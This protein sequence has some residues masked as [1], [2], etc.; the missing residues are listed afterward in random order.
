MWILSNGWGF[1]RYWQNKI[2]YT[3]HNKKFKLDNLLELLKRNGFKYTIYRTQAQSRYS[4]QTS[5]NIYATKL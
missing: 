4:N 5:G 3:I 1:K 2:E